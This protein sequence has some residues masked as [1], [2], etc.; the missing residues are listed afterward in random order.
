MKAEMDQGI[1]AA[2]KDL[3]NSA[4]KLR[5]RAKLDKA[6]MQAAAKQIED[7]FRQY[8]NDSAED[9]QEVKTASET[10]QLKCRPG[11]TCKSSTLDII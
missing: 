2:T 9:I 5:K 11:V 1:S 6:T 3:E 4:M 7:H 10:L 8:A